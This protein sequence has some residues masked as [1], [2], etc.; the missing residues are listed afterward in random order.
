MSWVALR[1]LIYLYETTMLAISLP[2][3]Q[4]YALAGLLD[5]P[6]ML[7]SHCVGNTVGRYI[8]QRVQVGVYDGNARWCSEVG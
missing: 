2:F 4:D 7:A 6:L 8:T 3:Q 1:T 5:C